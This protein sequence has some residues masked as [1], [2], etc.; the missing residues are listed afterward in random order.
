MAYIP[1]DEI[2]QPS[3]VTRVTQAV[4]APVTAHRTAVMLAAAAAAAS[5]APIPFGGIA[6]A[7]LVM[8][9]AEQ[10]RKR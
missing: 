5:A 8:V 2:P 6:A 1:E 4:V 10:A 7:F 9:A 3:R